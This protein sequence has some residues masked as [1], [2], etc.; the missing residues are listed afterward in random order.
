MPELPEVETI[1]RDLDPR[2][3][4]TRIVQV[5]VTHADVLAAPPERFAEGLEGLHITGVVRRGK[6]VV[7]RLEDDSRL[8]REPRSIIYRLLRP[9]LSAGRSPWRRSPVCWTNLRCTWLR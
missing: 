9:T 4:A 7:V 5:R 8:P 2:L 1:A 6:N 3:A